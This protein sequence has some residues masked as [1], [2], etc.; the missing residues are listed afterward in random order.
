[1]WGR[2]SHMAKSQDQISLHALAMHTRSSRGDDPVH[3]APEVIRETQVPGA[4]RGARRR[5]G[6]AVQCHS[7]P[8]QQRRR[9]THL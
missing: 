9:Q 3:A 7:R 8:A 1:M 5:H 2:H 6:R 4:V